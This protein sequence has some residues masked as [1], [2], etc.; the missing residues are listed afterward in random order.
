[1]TAPTRT[2]Y[3][4]LAAAAAAFVLYG[5]WVPF[6]FRAPPGNDPVRYFV[7]CLRDPD[8]IAVH[9]RSD[10]IG[11]VA[12]AVPLGFFLLAAAR[13]E[14][15]RGLGELLAA[16]ALWPLAVAV[17]VLA[18]FGQVFLP[19]RY[20]TGA[21]IWCQ[22]VG[23]AL[24]M[25]GWVVAGRWLTGHA[26]AVWDR[27]RPREAAGRLLAAYLLWVAAAQALPLDLSASP[28]EAYRK[29]RD[30]V[31][32]V[33][34]GEFGPGGPSDAGMKFVKL[35]GLFLPAGLLAGRVWATPLRPLALGVLLAGA[36]EAGQ[37]V[38][39]S[40]TPSATDVVAGTA[41]VLLGWAASRYGS[42]W[43]LLPAWLAALAVIFWAPFDFVGGAGSFG[44]LPGRPLEGHPLFALE[45]AVV[46]L[47]LFAPVGTAAGS[48][49]RGAL[50]GG[51]AALA[52]EV[53]QLFL[54]AHVPGVSDVILG[55]IGGAA[56]GW[57]AARVGAAA[58]PE[59][60]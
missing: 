24:G 45:D 47:A 10:S 57:A 21:D 36:T 28:A 23:A 35:V 26:R 16:L 39:Q 20:A 32:W 14:R 41:G 12:V 3:A 29:L 59:L 53:G 51:L 34:F 60:G 27:A 8:R 11:N 4:L 44:W 17:A 9:S 37:L 22:A 58:E 50:A 19:T 18:E 5:S 40:R 42:R 38:V 1:M 52:V 7:D 46:K 31:I 6:D 15:R 33:P 30:R 2:T 49:R 25:I 55:A 48:S 54:P 13:V 56:G 43:A